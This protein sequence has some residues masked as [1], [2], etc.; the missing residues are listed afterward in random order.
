MSLLHPSRTLAAALASGDDNFLLL[1]FIAAA[2]V[3]FGHSY[4]IA[5]GPGAADFIGRLELYPD[6]YTGSI[7]VDVFFVVSG[8]LVT[9]SWLN[10]ADAVGFVRARALRLLPAYLA[11]LVLTAYV[12]GTAVTSLPTGVYLT[13]P[14]T[15][16]YVWFNAL[17]GL[18]QQW[19]LPSVFE[20]NPFGNT[21]NGS[22]WTLPIEARMYVWLAVLGVLG[23]LRRRGLGSCVAALTA[24]VGIVGPILAP[25]LPAPGTL[26]LGGFFALGCL[27]Y[28][29]R[30]RIPL[31]NDVLVVLCIVVVF[32][33]RTPAF[34]PLFA[35]ALAYAT[36]WFAY[37]PRLGFFNRCG[38]YSYGLYLWGY[39]VQQ[40]VALAIGALHAPLLN[41][42]L[43]LPLTLLLAVASWHC[44]EKPALRWKTWKPRE[45]VA[46]SVNQRAA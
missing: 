28:L 38:D 8:F 9:G 17:F 41:F 2:T 3:I 1:R 18:R 33:A 22:L 11:C 26:T 13:A 27:C 4:G 45:T 31:R 29:Q 43:S 25:N 36:L 20:H 12:L 42:G 19:T 15:H 34:F 7:A 40:T 39:P 30:E 35:L 6:F 16:R 14:E 32:A 46:G 44:L 10:R 21:V 5:A 23:L 37:R 24:L